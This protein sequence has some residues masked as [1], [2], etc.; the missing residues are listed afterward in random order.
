MRF[1]QSSRIGIDLR[2]STC[3]LPAMN[4][5]RVPIRVQDGGHPAARKI[6][7]FDYKLSAGVLQFLDRLIEIAHFESNRPAIEEGLKFVRPPR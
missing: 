4:G 6:Q 2:P 3:G 5:D 1:G 7:R